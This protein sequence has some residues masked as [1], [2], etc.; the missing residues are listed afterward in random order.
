[1]PIYHEYEG[2]IPDCTNYYVTQKLMAEIVP[3]K[4]SENVVDMPK[5]TGYP[6]VESK[7]PRVGFLVSV[8]R[9][10]LKRGHDYVHSS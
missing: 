10:L 7:E 5:E 3:V 2:D 6:P 8:L 9:K 4:K 1:M